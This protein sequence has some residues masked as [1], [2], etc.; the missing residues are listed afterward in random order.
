MFEQQCQWKSAAL[1]A[2]EAAA[3]WTQQASQSVG[4]IA[5]R[6]VRKP[7]ARPSRAGQCAS[8]GHRP[9]LSRQ[10]QLAELRLRE[11]LDEYLGR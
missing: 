10:E 9:V 8:R 2:W 11:S 3:R 5:P 4:K 7:A 6:R 1:P